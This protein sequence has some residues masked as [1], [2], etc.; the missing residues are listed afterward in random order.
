MS[1]LYLSQKTMPSLDL[2]E[3]SETKKTVKKRKQNRVELVRPAGL[4]LHSKNIITY[5]EIRENF[6]QKSVLKICIINRKQILHNSH[7]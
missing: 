2:S 3:K 7:K 6:A 5:L 4:R 1:L